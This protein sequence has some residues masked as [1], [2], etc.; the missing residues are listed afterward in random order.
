MQL[1]LPGTPQPAVPE[2]ALQGDRDGA[3]VWQVR[4]G[5]AARVPV[6]PLRRQDGI[7][8]LEGQLRDGD[9][10]VV[11]G[12]QRLRDGRAVEVVGRNGG[13]PA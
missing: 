12:V 10:V 11:E 3:F 4:D 13:A 1:A 2:L 6:R 9:L 8:L 5:K 7:V